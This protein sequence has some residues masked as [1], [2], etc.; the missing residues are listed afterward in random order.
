[1]FESFGRMMSAVGGARVTFDFIGGILGTATYTNAATETYWDSAGVFQIASLDAGR[2]D[3][4]PADSDVALGLIFEA[5]VDND[6]PNPR[7]LTQAAWV[8][9]ST[10]VLKDATGVDG[11]ANAASTITASGAN[12]TCL[13]AVTESSAEFTF[14]ARVKR[15][16][17]TGRV[18]ITVDGGT[19]WNEITAEI[20][21]GEWERPLA[22]KTAANPSM[23]F[24]LVTS[25]DEI[26]VDMCQL[27]LGPHPTSEI[28]TGAATRAANTLV[29]TVAPNRDWTFVEPSAMVTADS[30]WVRKVI[31][32]NI[33]T[34][35]DTADV[36]VFYTDPADNSEASVLLTGESLT[37][38]SSIEAATFD[39]SNDYLLR[40]ADLTGNANSKKGIFAFDGRF[41]S[42]AILQFLYQN[43]G[44]R[45]SITRGT[46]GTWRVYAPSAATTLD[47]KSATTLTGTARLT[48]LA[49]WDMAVAGSARFYINLSSDLT[50]T[51]FV[52]ASIAYARIDHALGAQINTTAKFNGV[53]RMLY[54]NMAEYIDFDVEANRTKFFNTDNSLNSSAIGSDG[55]GPTGTIPIIFFDN[56]FGTFETNLGSGGGFTLTGTLTGTTWPP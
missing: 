39:G 27:E 30:R 38:T 52:D 7:D 48:V 28:T 2:F 32:T 33:D 15:K 18:D 6:C 20:S 3:H 16:T 25:G 44:V 13:D 10:T 51:T 46:D 56:P 26:E 11:V 22:T 45:I 17:G 36:E 31:F 24:R 4:D 19:T 14:S 37:D 50:E 34:V 12:G 23:G 43:S 9:A 1:M 35:A 29:F 55:S 53:C 49:S 5:A 54:F 21:T 40:G 42:D 47:I 41:D 8:K